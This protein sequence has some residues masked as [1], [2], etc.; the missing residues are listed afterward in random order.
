MSQ[1]ETSQDKEMFGNTD[2]AF[3]ILE[4]VSENYS[5]TKEHLDHF[6]KA[7]VIFNSVGIEIDISLRYDTIIFQDRT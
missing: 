7:I 3:Q 2:T 1:I 5:E 4:F 6:K